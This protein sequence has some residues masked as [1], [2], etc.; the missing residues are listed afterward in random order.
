[1][2]FVVK[3][4]NFVKV[5]ID[6]FYKEN[7]IKFVVKSCKFVKVST[8]VCYKENMSKRKFKYSLWYFNE[9]QTQLNVF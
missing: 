5:F 6:F 3:S 2:K 7:L 9:L 4:R 8:H 1:M